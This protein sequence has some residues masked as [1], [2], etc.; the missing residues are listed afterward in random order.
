LIDVRTPADAIPGCEAIRVPAAVEIES[1]E[2]RDPDDIR[3]RLEAG[4]A[5]FQT[6]F[7]GKPG[8]PMIR[9]QE[10]VT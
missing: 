10:E 3:E 9:L 1:T 4:P 6:N 7:Q 5:V 8:T 2:A